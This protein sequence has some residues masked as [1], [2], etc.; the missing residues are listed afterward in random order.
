MANKA[1]NSW[2]FTSSFYKSV[3]KFYLQKIPGVTVE[4]HQLCSAGGT[5][6]AVVLRALSFH[7]LQWD[8]EPYQFCGSAGTKGNRGLSS[9]LSIFFSFMREFFLLELSG[10]SE[11]ESRTSQ[12][13]EWLFPQK[14]KKSEIF[15]RLLAIIL[16]N[17]YVIK[18]KWWHTIKYQVFTD[19]H[20]L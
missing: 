5:Q 18:D 13:T 17:I 2:R 1:V 16:K 9:Y 19:I 15:E 12:K 3:C 14:K 11:T 7:S 8:R 20:S 10:V 6:P 4:A